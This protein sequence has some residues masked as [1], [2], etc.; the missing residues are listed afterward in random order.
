M[1]KAIAKT[2]SKPGCN[3]LVRDG[4]CSSCGPKVRGY[5]TD[6]HRGSRH[7]RGYDSAWVRLRNAFVQQKRLEAM[8]SGRSIQPICEVCGKPVP[9]Q[10]IHVDHRTPFNGLDDPLRLDPANLAIMHRECHMRKTA[11]QAK[12]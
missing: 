3:G 11:K 12:G 10:Q 9:D 6:K 1:A 7:A 4:N 2:C 5:A 8:K